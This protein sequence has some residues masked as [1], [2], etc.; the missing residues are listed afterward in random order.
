MYFQEQKPGVLFRPY[1]HRQSQ[2]HE[3]P[4]KLHIWE[5]Y[6]Q[7]KCQSVRGSDHKNNPFFLS[8]LLTQFSFPSF[9]QQ[10]FPRF[11]VL[12][13]QHYLFPLESPPKKKK[14]QQQFQCAPSPWHYS[15]YSPAPGVL[16]FEGC[17]PYNLLSNSKSGTLPSH[18]SSLHL[19]DSEGF[20]R[21]I[22]CK[23]NIKNED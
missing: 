12:N 16:W 20:K 11:H 3:V 5:I 7:G 10:L 22:S 4:V 6:F 18:I 23:S 17:P 14:Q 13:F 9:L 15:H 8:F 19:Y 2:S 21:L 1:D